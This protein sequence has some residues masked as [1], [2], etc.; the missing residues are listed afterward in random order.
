MKTRYDRK[1]SFLITMN[2]QRGF[3]GRQIQLRQ[4]KYTKMYSE[5]KFTP[6]IRV[7]KGLKLDM[8][9][10]HRFLSQ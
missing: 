10:S 8:T 1:S 9:G 4:I 2:Q 3:G 5:W 6:P 7:E